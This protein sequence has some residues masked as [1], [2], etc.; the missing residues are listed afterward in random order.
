M[1]PPVKGQDVLIAVRRE[2]WRYVSNK[3]GKLPPA[4]S[5]SRPHLARLWHRAHQAVKKRRNAKTVS[6]QG[7]RFGIV[8]MDAS[9]CVFDLD[10]RSILV[11]HPTSLASLFDVLHSLDRC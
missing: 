4:D 3:P 6:Y 9:L 10:T 11:R 8:Y 7:H 5:P 1:P 2:A